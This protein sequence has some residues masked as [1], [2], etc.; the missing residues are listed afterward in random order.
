VR[1]RT[2]RRAAAPSRSVQF[3]REGAVAARTLFRRRT[4]E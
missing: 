2:P 1:A 3:Q 4:I